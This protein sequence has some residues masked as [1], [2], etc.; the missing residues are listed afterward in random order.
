MQNIDTMQIV[1]YLRFQSSLGTSKRV[2]PEEDHCA[3]YRAMQWN[4]IQ[5]HTYSIT[6][7]FPGR[8]LLVL[9]SQQQLKQITGSTKK[10]NWPDMQG[11]IPYQEATMPRKR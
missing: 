11:G 5:P 7:T 4:Y 8:D 2:D 1:Y 3:G 9:F 10:L 6:C